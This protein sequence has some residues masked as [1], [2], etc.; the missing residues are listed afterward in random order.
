M[1]QSHNSG[2]APLFWRFSTILTL[3]E[4]HPAITLIDLQNMTHNT[5][6][7]E[8][9]TKSSI[10]PSA[11]HNSLVCYYNSVSILIST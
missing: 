1:E 9:Y 8:S 7:L 6:T 11:H 2:S 3:R 5:T 4:S 10:A